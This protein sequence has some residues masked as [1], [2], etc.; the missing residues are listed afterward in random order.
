MDYFMLSFQ[1]QDT[2]DVIHDSSFNISMFESSCIPKPRLA[3]SETWVPLSIILAALTVLG[4]L[5]SMLMQ[6]KILVSGAFYPR[7]ERERIRYL[8][9]KL[10]KK[11]AKQPP[12]E[13]ERK[14]SLYFKK[15]RSRG[16]VCL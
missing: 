11:R 9:A 15:V 3:V 14:L 8:H 12:G 10:L 6:L 2:Q 5:S 1:R 16:E 4:L 13:A 7:V